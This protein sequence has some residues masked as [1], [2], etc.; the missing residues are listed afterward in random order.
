L[1]PNEDQTDFGCCQ[2]KVGKRYIILKQKITAIILAVVVVFTC[3][4]MDGVT[5]L[6]FDHDYDLIS[7]KPKKTSEETLQMY[8]LMWQYSTDEQRYYF[9]SEVKARACGMKVDEFELFARVIEG[10][11]A[12]CKNDITDKT[13]IACVVLNRINCKRWPTKTVTRTV[14]R[15]NQFHAVNQKRRQC[16]KARSLDSEWAIIEA[17][18]LV[19]AK[20]I[21]C[22]MVYFNSK[23][24]TGYSRAFINYVDCGYCKGNYFSC[25][26]KCKC[27]YCTQ[28]DPDWRADKVEMFTGKIERPIGPIERTDL[29]FP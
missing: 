26:K 13:M 9:S 19:S 22:H 25:V 15:P 18:R 27:D 7:Y 2:L 24:F 11:G 8:D 3:L 14:L 5:A 20:K 17:V 12:F 28:W 10:E 16:Y 29:I 21:D 4:S 1:T 6:A 23:G